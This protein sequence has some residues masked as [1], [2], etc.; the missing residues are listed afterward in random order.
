MMGVL[1]RNVASPRILSMAHL[2]ICG[3]ARP[4]FQCFQPK[5]YSSVLS[6]FFL[7]P[8]SLPFFPPLSLSSSLSLRS[9]L[10]SDGFTHILYILICIIWTNSMY[11]YLI[12]PDLNFALSG[13]KSY[14]LIKK[15]YKFS[16]FSISMKHLITKL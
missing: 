3:L 6:H 1:Q 11:W 4:S 12:Y 16:S 13:K 14:H 10:F 9:H 7:L 8:P 5:S 15:Q 2:F